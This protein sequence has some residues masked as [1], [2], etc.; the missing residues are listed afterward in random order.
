MRIARYLLL[1]RL[2]IATVCAQPEVVDRMVA[3]VNKR[4]ILESELD[5]TV[6]VQLLLQNRPL[7]VDN[8]VRAPTLDQLIDRRLLEQQIT[9]LDVVDPTPEELAAR[10]KLA[11]DHVTGAST[12]EGWKSALAAYGVTERDVEDHLIS[13][14]RVLR[15]IDLHFRGL[16][17]IDKNAIAAYYT[18]KLLPQLSR[19]GAPPPPLADVSDKIE[20]ILVEERLDGMLNTWLQALRAQGRIRKLAP[21]DTDLTRETRP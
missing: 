4:I 11:R 5:Q 21:F 7:S 16:V 1:L 12:D 20:K 18:E 6:R 8:S 3:V 9:Q 2:L 19:Q 10:I 17:P 14:M 15:F 13:E